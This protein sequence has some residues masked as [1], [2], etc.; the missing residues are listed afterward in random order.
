MTNSNDSKTIAGSSNLDSVDYKNKPIPYQNA[1]QAVHYFKSA[2]LGS[3][4][5]LI[6]EILSKGLED[7][8]FNTIEIADFYYRINIENYAPLKNVQAATVLGLENNQV[9]LN[10]YNRVRNEQGE[11]LLT[12][13]NPE[14]KGSGQR[15][16]YIYSIES[17]FR[18]YMFFFLYNNPKHKYATNQLIYIMG[19]S[20]EDNGSV[21]DT[22]TT[23]SAKPRTNQADPTLIEL[24]TM[25]KNFD[26]M[27]ASMIQFVNA[28]QDTMRVNNEEIL[29][30]VNN[31][32]MLNTKA[33][34]LQIELTSQFEVKKANS[35]DLTAKLKESM[36]RYDELSKEYDQRIATENEDTSKI[37]FLQDE[38]ERL[39]QEQKGSSKAN[40]GFFQLFKK[41][42]AEKDYTSLIEAKKEQIALLESK[43][44]EG[45][46]SSVIA[47]EKEQVRKLGL[48][49]VDEV[50]NLNK[51]LIEINK[52]KDENYQLLHEQ[53]S[54]PLVINKTAQVD[55][56]IEEVLKILN[57][58]NT[59]SR[60][61]YEFV[62][63]KDSIY[64]NDSTIINTGLIES[65]G[66]SETV[67]VR[68]SKVNIADAVLI[69]D[70]DNN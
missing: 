32:Y 54:T 26:L 64:E 55:N 65:K 13:V 23:K 3:D 36:N 18:L 30:Q 31:N 45:R 28:V 8:L 7:D 29:N 41:A 53:I 12:Y 62:S 37:T 57:N 10:A 47:A 42:P 68:K 58:I 22:N 14:R 61:E 20:V 5:P 48:S 1:L 60:N 34:N 19:Y 6:A 38:I 33:M 51:E 17:I 24:A 15:S 49:I 16:N 2:F 56:K 25:N 9:I 59:D 21:I 52:Q 70:N 11:G 66:R 43:I 50:E 63:N 69:E 35:D 40:T 44:S 46:T 39:E 27:K 4:D 67:G